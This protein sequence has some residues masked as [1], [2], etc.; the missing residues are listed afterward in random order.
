MQAARQAEVENLY[1]AAIGQH[2]VLRLQVAMK[3]AQRMRSLQAVG[4]LNAHRK[5]KLRTRRT[6]RNQL[7]QRLAGHVLHHDVAFVAGLAHFV[8]GADIG[9]L[10]RRSQPR[11]AQHRRC[12][13][14]AADSRPARRIFS[15]TGRCSSV[16]LAR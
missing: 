7:V 16:S 12:A 3:D 8:D 1:Q 9:M 6:A 4:N 2:H 10:D 15:T 11:L 5:H 14:A 13:S